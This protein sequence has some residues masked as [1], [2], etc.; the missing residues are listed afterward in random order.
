MAV[1]VRRFLESLSGLRCALQFAG[2]VRCGYLW[3]SDLG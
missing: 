3:L 1:T 2:R